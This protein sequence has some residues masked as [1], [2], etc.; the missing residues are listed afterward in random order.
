MSNSLFLPFIKIYNLKCVTT[1]VKFQEE[2]YSNNS[3]NNHNSQFQTN[4][5]FMTHV[6]YIKERNKPILDRVTLKSIIYTEFTQEKL[7][8]YQIK[9][10]DNPINTRLM[11]TKRGKSKNT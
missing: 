8:W 11:L 3:I 5:T 2:P 7:E 1:Y 9:N 4:R 6:R 10:L